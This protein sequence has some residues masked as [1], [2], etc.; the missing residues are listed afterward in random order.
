MDLIFC[1]FL[2]LLDAYGMSWKRWD[3]IGRRGNG[4]E[5]EGNRSEDEDELEEAEIDSKERGM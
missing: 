4:S 5:D 3:S 2:Y 1:S